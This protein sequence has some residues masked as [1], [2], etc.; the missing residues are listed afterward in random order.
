MADQFE[1]YD[2]SFELGQGGGGNETVKKIENIWSSLLPTLKKVAVIGTIKRNLEE[3]FS[4]LW[5]NEMAKFF[6]FQNSKK[7]SHF[8]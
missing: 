8:E 7:F 4:F 2:Q 3:V 5:K 6:A 1:L